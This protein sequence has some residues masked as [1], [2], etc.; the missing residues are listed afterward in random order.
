[1]QVCRR[2]AESKSKGEKERREG[3]R[4]GGRAGGQAREWKWKGGGQQTAQNP[5]AGRACEQRV[6]AEHITGKC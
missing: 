2:G 3:E 5:V 1:M 6:D 4:R